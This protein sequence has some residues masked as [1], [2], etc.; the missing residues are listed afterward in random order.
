M[1][2]HLYITLLLILALDFFVFSQDSSAN[3]KTGWYYVNDNNKGYKMKLDKD[4]V[5]YFI[6]PSPIITSK[7]IKSLAIYQATNGG[8]GI[9][10]EFDNE[11]TAAWRLATGRSIG[12]YLAFILNNLVL[13]VPKV[14]SEITAGVAVLER[15]IYLQ[16]DLEKI[17][18]AIEKGK[19]N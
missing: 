11:G 13:Y 4:S 12:K 5:Q 19:L 15:D 10:M 2:K 14:N 8:K 3:L 7:N 16:K 17:K 18:I 9:S 1:L 6:D